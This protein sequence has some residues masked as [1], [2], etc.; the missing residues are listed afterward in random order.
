MARGKIEKRGQRHRKV[1]PV[2]LIVTEGSLHKKQSRNIL[3]TTVT[4]KLILI[5]VSLAAEAAGE[6]PITSV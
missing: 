5:F 3:H 1:K 6:K 4:G 2:I